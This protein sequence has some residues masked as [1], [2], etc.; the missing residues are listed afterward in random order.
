MHLG[1]TEICITKRQFNDLIAFD[2][3]ARILS[4]QLRH[5]IHPRSEEFRGRQMKLRKQLLAPLLR[6]QK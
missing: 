3:T 2:K 6:V 4:R 5:R 1:I